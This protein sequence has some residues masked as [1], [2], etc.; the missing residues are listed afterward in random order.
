V[1]I[2]GET[3]SGKSTQIPQYLDEAGWTAGGRVV[4]CTQPRRVAATSVA[5][6]VAEEMG[7][8][9][10]RE[11]GFAVRFEEA[12]SV[13][14]RILYVTDGMLVR[15]T[16]RDPLLTRFSVVMLDEAHERS[17]A[18]DI[19]LG[20]LKKILRKRPDLRLIVSSATIDA[21]LIR[22]FFEDP[23]AGVTATIMSI[24]GRTFPVE[25]LYA[26]A[27]VADYVHA[28]VDAAVAIHATEQPGDVLVFL[29]GQEEIDEAVALIRERT[30]DPSLR[31][32]FVKRTIVL[33]MYATLPIEDQMLVFE[34]APHATR[35][36]CHGSILLLIKLT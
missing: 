18:T 31:P 14:T 11:V 23:A 13:T 5:R 34:P 35:K 27:P 20:L 29:T 16:M 6:R 12:T 26:A 25:T 17:L 9:V 8:S 21:E 4:C 10:G 3:G 19:L 30:S 32:R 7:T 24:E 15:E 33:P 1:V 22:D 36:V 2:V 28:A